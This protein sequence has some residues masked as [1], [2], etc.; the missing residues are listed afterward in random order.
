MCVFSRPVEVLLTSSLSIIHIL[1]SDSWTDLHPVCVWTDWLVVLSLSLVTRVICCFFLLS[2]SRHRPWRGH[3]LR[4]KQCRP[5]RGGRPRRRW[6]PR[7]S[8][9]ELW[10]PERMF[11]CRGSTD[12]E[13]SRD[14]RKRRSKYLRNPCFKQVVSFTVFTCPY[15]GNL[16]TR[17]T[18]TVVTWLR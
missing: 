2:L 11:Y 18:C 7:S 10:S 15:A 12:A 4:L 17:C 3:Q 1:C 9:G 16:G 5:W 8:Y 13:S 14:L 6:P